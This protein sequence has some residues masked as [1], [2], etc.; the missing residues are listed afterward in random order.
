MQASPGKRALAERT[1]LSAKTAGPKVGLGREVLA[2]QNFMEATATAQFQSQAD[3]LFRAIRRQSRLGI[4][5]LQAVLT[6][7]DVG[8]AGPA[9]EREGEAG[10]WA[11]GLP[12][13]LGLAALRSGQARWRFSW[14]GPPTLTGNDGEPLPLARLARL[15]SSAGG[16]NRAA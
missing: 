4:L 3:Q 15:A 8:R 5:D 13:L 1:S 9:R 12:V 2:W 16:V 6:L 11:G 10:D 14:T 7:F